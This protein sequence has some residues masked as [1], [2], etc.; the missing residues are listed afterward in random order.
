MFV[1][2]IQ[3]PFA[4]VQMLLTARQ[5]TGS[6]AGVWTSL[7]FGTTSL[8]VGATYLQSSSSTTLR[9]L[10]AGYFKVSY[11]ARL[12]GAATGS[13]ELR[14]VKNGG[15]TDV[16]LS[17]RCSGSSSANTAAAANTFYVSAIVLLAA[18]DTLTL[19]V[20]PVTG[21]AMNVDVPSMFSLKLE[22]L[23]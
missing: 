17:L 14:V 18:N 5:T 10:V 9:A 3:K 19:Q 7:A 4:L 21:N 22:Q 15:S 8:A 16:D 2:N 20:N 13:G 11:R 12:W 6:T 1:T 23:V